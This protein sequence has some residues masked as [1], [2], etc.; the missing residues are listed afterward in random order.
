MI[1]LS[2]LDFLNCVSLSHD[3]FIPR[4]AP[5]LTR[6][7][8]DETLAS[9]GLEPTES[10]GAQP[11]QMRIELDSVSIGNVVLKRNLDH[12]SPAKIPTAC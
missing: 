1:C 5:Q 6:I 12:D 8:F 11:L 9:C 3:F 4:F 2:K 10:G 7:A